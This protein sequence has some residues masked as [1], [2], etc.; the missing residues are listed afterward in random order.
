MKYIITVVMGM[1]LIMSL[2]AQVINVPKKSQSH[3][4]KK[5]PNA[6]EVNWIN[7]VTD[8]Q[9]KFKDEQGTQRA[10]YHM[11]GTWDFTELYI[12]RSKVPAAVNSSLSKSRFSDWKNES[13]ALV[14][15]NKGQK[16]YRLEMKKGVEKKFVFYDKDGKEIK[17]AATT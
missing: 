16:L 2:E 7:N 4:G 11:D 6:K 1:F 13:C 10:Y 5:Y 15:N 14:E 12:E 3:F 8:Y 17:T 9:V